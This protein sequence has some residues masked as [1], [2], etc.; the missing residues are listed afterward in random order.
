MGGRTHKLSLKRANNKASWAAVQPFLE[1]QQG[2]GQSTTARAQ[3]KSQP[4]LTAIP[5]LPK[6]REPAQHRKIGKLTAPYAITQQAAFA[7]IE[8]GGSQFKVTTDDVIYHNKIDSMI[9]DVIEFGRVLLIGTQQDTTIGRPFIPGA[10]VVAAI[11]ETFKDAKVHVFKKKKR[12]GYSKL[13]GYRAQ[14][15]ALR[16]LEIRA[17][18]Q[19]LPTVNSSSQQQSS[20]PAA[21]IRQLGTSSKSHA[22]SPDVVRQHQKQQQRQKLL[23]QQKQQQQAEDAQPQQQQ[24]AEGRKQEEEASQ[25]Q[26][27]KQQQPQLQQPQKETTSS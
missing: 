20:L 15:T 22:A 25:Q 19:Q 12:K 18:G 23:Q 21:E 27:D 26:H 13:K 4:I 3:Q 17:P 11:E 24:E 6:Q 10:S 16:I 1:Q 7:V 9:N 8:T 5:E 2:T 14:M